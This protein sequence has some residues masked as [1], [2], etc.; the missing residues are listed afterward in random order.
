MDTPRPAV[1]P[2]LPPS[3]DGTVWSANVL[4]AHQ[5]L[6]DAYARAS[7]LLRQE[8]GDP[9]RLRIHS[10]RILKRMI[11]ILEAL[12][13][14]VAD[15]HWS[16]GCAHALAKITV[17]LE[18][19]AFAADGVEQAKVHH[20]NPV[21][22]IRTGRRGRPRKVIN[23]TWLNEAMSTH[24]KISIQKLADLLGM[25][26]N[27]VSKQLKLYGVYQRFSDIS[28]NDIDLLVRLYKKHR[29]MSGLRYVIGFLKSHGLRV[30]KRRL[31]IGESTTS[32]VLTICGIWM[33]TI[34]SYGGVLLFMALW[35]DS[36]GV[37]S[38]YRSTQIIVPPQFSTCFL[39]QLQSMGYHPGFEEI[40]EARI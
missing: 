12:D 31:S 19:A 4:R 34:S 18:R 30:Q 32:L 29:P 13:Q 26:R 3:V 2:P 5:I 14:E 35:M 27:A 21:T 16:S 20:F 10:E 23:P 28:D 22:I 24:R 7:D 40:V 6:H 11:P 25:H 39:M 9:L 1:F 33:A 36:V 38:E 8:D 15:E 37:L 17:D